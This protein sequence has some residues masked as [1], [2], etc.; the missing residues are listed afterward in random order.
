MNFQK[1]L[2]LF[3]ELTTRMRAWSEQR[4]LFSLYVLFSQN[5]SCDNT[6]ENC[7]FQISFYSRAYACIHNLWKDKGQVPL[8]SLLWK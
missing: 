5:M 7:F 6:L 4:D 3:C 1:N 2:E 8:G